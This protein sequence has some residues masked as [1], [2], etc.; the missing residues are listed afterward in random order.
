[1]SISRHPSSPFMHLPSM[2]GAERARTR[3][4]FICLPFPAA[5]HLGFRFDPFAN[6]ARIYEPAAAHRIRGVC[7]I[8]GPISPNAG[9]V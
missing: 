2:N 1:M 5:A 6:F 3:I 7:L 8:R 9:K 4:R